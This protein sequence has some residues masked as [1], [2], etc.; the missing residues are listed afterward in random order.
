[1]SGHSKFANIKHKK[2]KN[3]AAKGKIFTKIGR[4]LAIAVK[5]GGS[6]DPVNN[7]RLRDVI[8]KAKANNMLGRD[9]VRGKE[10]VV[11]EAE[12]AQLQR[13][14]VREVLRRVGLDDHERV[15]RPRS[16]VHGCGRRR[17]MDDG[18]GDVRRRDEV[19]LVLPVR[20]I[21]DD[22]AV[23]LR[24]EDVL[25]VA[26][27]REQ[28]VVAREA[29]RD[30]LFQRDVEFVAVHRVE[31]RGL[32]QR[33]V[34]RRVAEIVV[35]HALERTA[36]R[37]IQVHGLRPELLDLAV[38]VHDG[39]G[40]GAQPEQP[41]QRPFPLR[42]GKGHVLFVHVPESGRIRHDPHEPVPVVPALGQ[43]RP[44]QGAG[45]VTEGRRALEQ[46]DRLAGQ[47]AQQPHEQ[48]FQA[49]FHFLSTFRTMPPTRAFSYPFMDSSH[50]EAQ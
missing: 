35:V 48:A 39:G 41:Q 12:V 18:D 50:T 30:E 11:D 44:V 22:E 47:Q 36:V 21:P 4:E 14:D 17:V 7:S 34:G 40:A 10:P 25:Q 33:P 23:K 37:Q 28:V 45:V 24:A 8:A 42:A 46:D 13:A 27:V 31:K 9:A 2:E 6:A 5:E 20:G 26:F 29:E 49:L 43:Q 3:D 1:M 19:V 32:T 38:A 16:L 15:C